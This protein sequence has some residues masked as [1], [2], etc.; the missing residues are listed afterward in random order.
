VSLNSKMIWSESNTQDSRLSK[1]ISIGH[2]R[3]R[4]P[5]EKE[6]CRQKTKQIS[7]SVLKEQMY[8]C[9]GNS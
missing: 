5:L 3:H 8:H 9:E 7:D 4:L 1:G 2:Q 6:E